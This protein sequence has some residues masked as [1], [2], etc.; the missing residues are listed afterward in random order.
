MF[1][2]NMTLGKFGG[3]L[4]GGSTKKPAKGIHKLKER[5]VKQIVGNFLSS[6]L[7]ARHLLHSCS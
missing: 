2:L 6:V 5:V 4:G 3:Q 7:D 1:E